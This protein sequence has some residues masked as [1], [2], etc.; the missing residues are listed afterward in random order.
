M[1]GV[2]ADLK[3]VKVTTSPDGIV[4]VLDGDKLP[5]STRMGVAEFIRRGF[6]RDPKYLRVPGLVRNARLLTELH[7]AVRR[8]EYYSLEVCSPLCCFSSEQRDDPATLLY[9][10]RQFDYPISSGGWRYFDNADMYSASL[11]ARYAEGGLDDEA[12]LQFE[13]ASHPAYPAVTFIKHLDQVSVAALLGLIFD[14]RWYINPLEPDRSNKLQQFLG[15]DPKCQAAKDP[16]SGDRV[17]RNRLVL[18]CWKNGPVPTPA[19]I[20]PGQFLW[21]TWYARGGGTRGDLAASKRLV[22]YLRQSWLMFVCR[23]GMQ[24]EVFV[25]KLFFGA[26]SPDAAAFESHVGRR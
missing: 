6:F 13:L 18:A 21:K 1:T 10:A 20:G 25:P 9:N 26:D 19:D 4:W 24:S 5:R 17:A 11:T 16:S 15:L 8:D 22:D 3:T 2:I 7:L 14:P 23:G 12:T